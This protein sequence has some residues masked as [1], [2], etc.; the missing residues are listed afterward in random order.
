M[1][2]TF[3]FHTIYEQGMILLNMVREKVPRGVVLLWRPAGGAGQAA[4]VTGGLQS[5]R[6]LKEVMRNMV[7]LTRQRREERS[8]EAEGTQWRHDTKG[9]VVMCEKLPVVAGA[10]EGCSA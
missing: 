1:L 7:E 4:V 6:Y 10:W 9:K 8:F 5:R 3:V 2:V